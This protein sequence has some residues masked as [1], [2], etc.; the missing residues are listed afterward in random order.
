MEIQYRM[1]FHNY[2]HLL[3]LNYKQTHKFDLFYSTTKHNVPQLGSGIL[4]GEG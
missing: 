1:Y 4:S 2:S 3:I